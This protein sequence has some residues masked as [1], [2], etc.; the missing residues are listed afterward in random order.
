MFAMY[1]EFRPN[2]RLAPLLECG[3]ARS[4]SAV[5]PLRVLP[6]GCVDL[7]VSSLGDVM[8]AGPATGFYDLRSDKE[9]VYVGLRLR[10]GAAAAVLGR[11]VNEFTDSRVPL[12]STLGVRAHIVAERVFATTSPSQCVAMLQKI[13]TGYL[14]D[15]EPLIDAAVVRAIRA[16][17]RRP[18]HPV[19]ALAVDVDLSERQLRR[20][21]AT[22]V[23]YGPKR[24][25]RILRFQRLLDL[26]RAQGDR[27]RWAELAI[28]ANY[29]DQ[30][31]M[32]HECLALSGRSPTALPGGVSVS[33]NTSSAG[34]S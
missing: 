15:T 19:S 23:G 2:P 22:T 11:P 17:Q 29:A 27:V 20:R 18:D 26:I 10:P 24:L 7:F 21:F 33:F 6:D 4:D 34:T 14:A 28:D 3:W 5:R 12:D 32:I 9:C 1:Q 13:L 30:A 25:S 8:I 16:L 31:H